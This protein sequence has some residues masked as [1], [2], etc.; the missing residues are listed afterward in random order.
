MAERD[1][2]LAE[3]T[4]WSDSANGVATVAAGTTDSAAWNGEKIHLTKARDEALSEAQ[5]LSQIISIRPTLMVD[6]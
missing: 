5:V 2:L 1:T 6:L 4:M 3:K